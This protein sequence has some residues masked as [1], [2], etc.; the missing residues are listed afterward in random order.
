M[1]NILCI[2]IGGTRIK[3]AILKNDMDLNFLKNTKVEIIRSLGWLNSSLPSL[4]SKNHPASIIQQYTNL[5]DYDY[6]S[7]SVPVN[8]INDGTEINGNYV[9]RRGLP[10]DLKKAFEE[11][12][13]CEVFI[14]NDSICWL[15]GALNYYGLNEVKVEFPCLLIALGTGVG[16]GYASQ[17]YHMENLE[18]SNHYH[19][20][21]QLSQ[22]SVQLIDRGWKVHACLGEK[23]FYSLKNEHKDWTYLNIQDDFTKRITALLLDIK[24]KNLINF[25]DLKTIFIGGGN[26][27]YVN[28]DILIDDLQKNVLILTSRSLQINPD[29]IP[30]LG[31]VKLF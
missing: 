30:L 21:S 27:S 1:S 3:A 23:Y 8:V 14:M 17:M 7:I 20:F 6:I 28:S 19:R 22:A 16:L 12:S 24:D 31:Q 29:L 5:T 26:A 9:E 10:Q 4:I 15:S 11:K 2:D 25:I 13:K 18:L